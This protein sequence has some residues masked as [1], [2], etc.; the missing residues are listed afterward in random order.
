MTWSMIEELSA[1]ATGYYGEAEYDYADGEANTNDA[2]L[3][4]EDDVA[5]EES[6]IP[7]FHEKTNS[8]TLKIA[9]K[10]LDIIGISRL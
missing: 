5:Y 6:V 1:G 3:P 8:E 9:D 4:I 10:I 7:R 2:S